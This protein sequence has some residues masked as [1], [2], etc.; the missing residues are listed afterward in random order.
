MATRRVAT[1][2]GGSGF[3]GRYV[4]KRLA[5]R[6]DIVRVAV[7]DPEA[8]AFLK[9]MGAVG[10][11]VPLYANLGNDTSVSR[12]VDGADQVV[13]LV[14]ILAEKRRGDFDRVQAEGPARIA[15][16]ATEAGVQRLVHV[17]AIGANA[18]S[19]SHYASS[20]GK[21][22]DAVRAAFPTATIL[23]P[24]LVFG[25]EDQ[26]FNRFAQLALMLPFMPVIAGDS[27]FQP[28]H[29]GDVADAVMA[30][31]TREDALGGLYELGGPRVWRFR[32]L[33][34]YILLQTDHRRLLVDIPMSLARL[35]AAVCE[36]LPS[37][38]L[39]R[40]Q[41]LLLAQDNVVGADAK[42]LADLGLSSCPVELVVPTY[43]ARYRSG[44]RRPSPIM[45]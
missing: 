4:V 19:P 42:T 38:P 20:K 14:G 21:G 36:H 27:R 29:V 45:G 18:A 41:L 33:L 26:F 25:P 31:L 37:K 43:L 44:G 11:V 17:S 13:N 5:A 16:L 12:A 1:V 40:D 39:T 22:E 8:A 10:Q 23:R 24:S 30:A 32:E 6:G 28:V 34:A 35:Q 7:R 3:I 15:R 2:F 9:P